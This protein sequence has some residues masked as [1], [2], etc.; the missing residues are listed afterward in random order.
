VDPRYFRPAEVDL[1]VGDAAKARRVLGWTP[2]VTL[3]EMVAEMVRA[4]LAAIRG[5]TD[6]ILRA[7]GGSM[8]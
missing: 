7:A 1:L 4:D 5:G 3:P 8:P 2:T 6:P